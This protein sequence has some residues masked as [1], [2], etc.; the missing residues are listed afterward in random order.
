MTWLGSIIL[1]FWDQTFQIISEPLIALFVLGAL[2]RLFRSLYAIF[3]SKN[4]AENIC[5]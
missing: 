2:L 4:N 3:A 1:W 5:F